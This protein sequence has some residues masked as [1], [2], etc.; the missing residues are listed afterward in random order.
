ML[1]SDVDRSQRSHGFEFIGE[2]EGAVLEERQADAAHD[3]KAVRTDGAG[4]AGVEETEERPAWWPGHS[5]RDEPE[6][7]RVGRVALGLWLDKH[8]STVGQCGNLVAQRAFDGEDI[9]RDDIRTLQVAIEEIEQVLEYYA[10]PVVE[11][12]ERREGSDD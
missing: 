1:S 9:T 2:A 3:P 10:I 5:D 4:A 6:L 7:S 12:R 8:A 11:E